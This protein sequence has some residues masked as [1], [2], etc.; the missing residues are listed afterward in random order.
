MI[1]ESDPKPLERIWKKTLHTAP[2]RLQ[3]MIMKLQLNNLQ[4]MYVP[5]KAL[6]HIVDALIHAYVRETGD[7]LIDED[8]SVNMIDTIP[9][10]SHYIH[11]IQ[12]E[13]PKDPT[14]QTL[15]DVVWNRWPVVPR[16]APHCIC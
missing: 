14:L 6:L 16:Q 9:V 3:K 7:P 11:T 8:L 15:M 2:M 10:S 12:Q 1:V 5:A 13:T 4:I